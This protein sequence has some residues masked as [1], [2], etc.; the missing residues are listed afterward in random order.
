M[1]EFSGR[2]SWYTEVAKDESSPVY[3]AVYACANGGSGVKQELRICI[4]IV[5]SELQPG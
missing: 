3:L 1:E 4:A 2:W 5:T